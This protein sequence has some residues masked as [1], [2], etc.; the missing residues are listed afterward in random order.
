MGRFRPFVAGVLI[1][2]SGDLI[3]EHRSSDAFGPVYASH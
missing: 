2:L 1:T 3:T